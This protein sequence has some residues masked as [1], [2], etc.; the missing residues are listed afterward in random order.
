MYQYKDL[1][2]DYGIRISE[3]SVKEYDVNLDQTE[4]SSEK[5]KVDL[6]PYYGV[7]SGDCLY[8]P[9]TDEFL[10]K[11]SDSSDIEPG[12][13]DKE[14]SE[15]EDKGGVH[16]G[17]IGRNNSG[18]VG[19]NLFWGM[20]SPLP[21]PVPIVEPIEPAATSYQRSKRVK[22]GQIFKSK[23][24]LKL[25]LGLKCL[26]E[27]YQIKTSRSTPS[28]FEA[29]CLCEKC[30][31][32]IRA[33]VIKETMLFQVRVFKDIHT[34]SRTQ[35]YPNHRQANKKVLGH[36][37][38]D[39]MNDT[40]TIYKGKEIMVDMKNNYKIDASYKQAWLAKCYALLLLRGTQRIHL[41]CC[42]YTATI[43][44]KLIRGL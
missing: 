38:K 41:N 17:N 12:E 33:T 31:W 10:E 15:K 29:I 21:T 37:L 36:I 44:K 22:V 19:C 4:N 1:P 5:Y 26:E 34:C 40:S 32:R 24:E 20:P 8:H 16:S 3:V 35:V 39:A 14:E 6:D 42:Q 27:C 7:V 43:W 13:E 28:R 25:E 11:R 23:E 18:P 2:S 9:N 30:E